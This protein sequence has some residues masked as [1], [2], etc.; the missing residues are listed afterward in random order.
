MNTKMSKL[1][2]ALGAMVVAGASIAATESGNLTVGA[3]VVNA[4]SSPR[5][6]IA[7]TVTNT[8]DRPVTFQAEGDDLAAG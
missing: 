4:C 2:L 5:K 6:A 3:T 7:V 1:L 8:G